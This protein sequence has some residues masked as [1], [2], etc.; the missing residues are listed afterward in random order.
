[1]ALVLDP[2]QRIEFAHATATI[3][4]S[5]KT[6]RLIGRRATLTHFG[7]EPDDATNDLGSNGE[8]KLIER[9][10]HRRSRWLG[11][12]VKSGVKANQALTFLYPSHR[13]SALPGVPI[14]MENLTTKRK[15]TMQL[16][17]EIGV[18]IAYMSDNR[19][20]FDVQLWGKTGNPYD[21]PILHLQPA[22]NP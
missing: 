19:P 3:T 7:F 4:H 18:L 16:D 9:K 6:I 5:G 17:G 1:M 2:L 21:E 11:D 8:D 10:A 12:I 20:P 14:V 15:W 13:G 22:P